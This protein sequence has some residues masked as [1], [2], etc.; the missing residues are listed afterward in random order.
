MEWSEVNWDLSDAV[1]A[2]QMGCHRTYVN[3]MRR[4]C[5]YPRPTVDKTQPPTNRTAFLRYLVRLNLFRIPVL[6]RE[7]DL[8]QFICCLPLFV[9]EAVTCRQLSTAVERE[10]YR[11][12][13]SYG[14]FKTEGRWDRLE[15]QKQEP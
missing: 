3:R 6:R 11:F 2:I 5:G 7:P 9:K 4:T 10:F 8:H 15:V 1:L 13:R 14:Y 12:A